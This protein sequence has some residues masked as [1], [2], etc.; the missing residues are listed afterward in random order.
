MSPTN[1]LILMVDQMSGCLLDEQ[2]L[3]HLHAP[4]IK[5]LIAQGVKFENAYCA[6]PLCTPYAPT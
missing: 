2:M 5:G 3:S 4:N 6:S 1:F